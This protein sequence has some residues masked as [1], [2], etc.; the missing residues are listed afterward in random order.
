[1]SDS[2]MSSRGMEALNGF[3]SGGGMSG[4]PEAVMVPVRTALAVSLHEVFLLAMAVA[5]VAAVVAVFMREI[6]LRKSN[7]EPE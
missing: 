4:V 3:S 5:A 7:T 6:P 2:A 1:M